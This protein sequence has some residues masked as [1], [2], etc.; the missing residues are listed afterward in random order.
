MR[1]NRLS[2]SEG[3][4]AGVTTGPPYPYRGSDLAPD[5]L[6]ECGGKFLPQ[7]VKKLLDDL[8]ALR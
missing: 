3:G 6:P 8:A 1:E 7:R 2:G 5:V 4:G